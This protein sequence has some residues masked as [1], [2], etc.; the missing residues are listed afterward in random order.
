[1]LDLAEEFSQGCAA[2]DTQ[3]D[4]KSAEKLKEEGED[5]LF[6]AV[7]FN[8]FHCNPKLFL[9]FLDLVNKTL[10][11]RKK[12]MA[13]RINVNR[14]LVAPGKKNLDLRQEPFCHFTSVLVVG[15]AAER[16]KPARITVTLSKAERPE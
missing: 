6:L 8:C 11:R 16:P 2:I 10:H 5:H 15:E 12:Q 7:S 4:F 1:M 13:T 3:Q 14:L 9:P